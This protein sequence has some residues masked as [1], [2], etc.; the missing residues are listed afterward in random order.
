MV[1]IM[2]GDRDGDGDNK[3]N[4]A[5]SPR[6]KLKGQIQWGHISGQGHINGWSHIDR[7]GIGK[8][9]HINKQGRIDKLDHNGRHNR[10]ASWG[11]MTRSV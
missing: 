8:K 10:I 4:T 3:A 6:I 5:R 9:S 2:E 11:S 1:T 7:Q